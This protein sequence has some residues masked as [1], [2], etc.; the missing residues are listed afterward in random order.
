[1]FAYVLPSQPHRG[2][3]L[4]C[5]AELN[6]W[7]RKHVPYIKSASG[8]DLYFALAH[9]S[10]L[11]KNGSSRS[12]KTMLIGLTDRAIRQRLREFEA[13]GLITLTQHDTDARA[14]KVQ[15]TSKLLDV[16]DAHTSEMRRIFQTRFTFVPKPV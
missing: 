9:C 5:I 16:F 13:L 12:L 2:R 1:M 6:E 10:L 11:Q 7:E 15:P 8:R 4:L 14:R 3:G